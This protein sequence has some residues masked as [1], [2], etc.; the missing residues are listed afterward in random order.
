MR[1]YEVRDDIT[2][3]EVWSNWKKQASV[4]IPVIHGNLVNIRLHKFYSRRDNITTSKTQQKYR[5]EAM[6][7]K[8]YFRTTAY[9]PER[10]QLVNRAFFEATIIN[11]LAINKAARNSIRSLWGRNKTR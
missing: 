3:K 7:Q 9:R 8:D 6:Q 5:R 11:I 2:W 1:K 10:Q 4:I